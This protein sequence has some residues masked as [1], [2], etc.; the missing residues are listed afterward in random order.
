LPA[1]PTLSPLFPNQSI[2]QYLDKSSPRRGS[3]AST[4]PP[5]P[6]KT[7]PISPQAASK[8]A[9]SSLLSALNS[10]SGFAGGRRAS[11][12][13][14]PANPNFETEGIFQHPNTQPQVQE[15]DDEKKNSKRESKK[16]KESGQIDSDYLPISPNQDGS[17]QS[18]LSSSS[19]S[20]WKPQDIN[21]DQQ[22]SQPRKLSNANIDGNA[23]P[24]KL[25][26]VSIEEKQSSPKGSVM[27]LN[28]KP[29]SKATPLSPP[30]PE[31]PKKNT[32][33]M[34]PIYS[35]GAFLGYASPG[36]HPR[37]QSS[38]RPIPN[39]RM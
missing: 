4:A 10:D 7:T 14:S 31:P 17:M 1:Q 2:G 39:P 28:I 32:S 34:A 18:T 24:R 20:T 27:A 23:R 12:S 9:P 26:I 13:A 11:E 25:S 19:T 8:K 30:P 3:E 5:V 29:S 16:K 15:L 6:P 38:P 22:G 33:L 21:Q 35:G 37:P 36:N